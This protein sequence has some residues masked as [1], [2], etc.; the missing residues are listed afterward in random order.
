[1]RQTLGLSTLAI[2]LLAF[3]RPAFALS[4]E[5]RDGA[6][7]FKPDTVEK[8]DELIKN[9][10]KKHKKDLLI[11][12]FSHVP[13]GDEKEASSSDPQEKNHFF[14]EWALRR[15]RESQVNGIYVLIC[16]E[17]PY[18]KVAVGNETRKVF[19][20]DERND[21]GSILV[22]RFKKKEY[23]DG[24]LEGVRYVDSAL[25]DVGVEPDTAH[26]AGGGGHHGS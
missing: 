7:F 14:T 3:A 4:P 24:L 9:I 8:A 16:R 19:T 25:K 23:D 12:T 26:H 18:I 17:P 21:L 11:E 2:V 13:A 6:G 22:N 1:M 10:K 20:D 15:A 5:V